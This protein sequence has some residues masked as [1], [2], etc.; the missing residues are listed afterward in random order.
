MPTISQ[1]PRADELSS[2][3]LLPI[4]QGGS[5]Y[6]VS[7]GSLLAG[8]QPAIAIS[9]PSL[10]GRISLGPGGPEEISIGNGLV[11]NNATLSAEKLDTA[12]I[13]IQAEP[14]SSDRI[15][16]DRNGELQLVEFGKVRGLFSAGANISIDTA[17][18]I[19][20][21]SVRDDFSTHFSTL[22]PTVSL[23]T[24]DLIGISHG[25][26]DHV[27][28]YANLI[29]GITISEARAADPTTDTDTIWTGQAD[30]VMV[31]QNFG[32]VWRWIV[33]KLPLFRQP[34]V[35]L[36][37]NTEI[38]GS[39]HNNTFLVC[40]APVLLDGTPAGLGRG[41]K[42]EVINASAGIVLFSSNLHVQG[43]TAAI[44]PGQCCT[45]QCVSVNG[46]LTVFVAGPSGNGATAI[47]GV[48]PSVAAQDQTSH[49]IKLIWEAPATGGAPEGYVI[50]YRPIN[51][52]TWRYLYQRTGTYAAV[53]DGL[54]SAMSYDFMIVAANAAGPGPAYDVLHTATSAAAG[55]PGAPTSLSISGITTN[56]LLLSGVAPHASPHFH[57]GTVAQ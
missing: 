22:T 54:L 44:L 34:C 32:E 48:V 5:T 7:V 53:V 45:I 35:E 37:S 9:S 24:D 17:G 10:L 41:F 50:K 3:D 30:D 43:G 40:A 39:L 14:V 57:C 26:Q 20:A 36:T 38:E 56:S 2:A 47:P 6:A 42:C 33:A 23:V 16:A 11:L 49:S 8:S 18:V 51:E 28:S 21:T 15:V 12:L 25:G 27:V 13:Q 19:S 55:A 29:D 31:R 1:L 46:N 4:S 52:V